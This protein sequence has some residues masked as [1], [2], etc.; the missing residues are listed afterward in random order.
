MNKISWFVKKERITCIRP[1]TDEPN[2]ILD[3]GPTRKY[4]Y[5]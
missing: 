5:F 4:A 1:H 2:E 3:C